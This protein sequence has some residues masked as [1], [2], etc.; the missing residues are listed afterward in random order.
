MDDVQI[1][2][3][4][5]I[6]AEVVGGALLVLVTVGALLLAYLLLR[7]TRIAANAPAVSCGLRE[8]GRQRWRTSFVLLGTYELEA[9]S[10]LGLRMRPTRTWPR[11]LLEVSTPVDPV[12]PVPALSDAVIVTLTVLDSPAV[13]E[14]AVERTAYPA[15]RSW[16]ESAPPR[17][18]S[19]V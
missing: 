1:E 18:N 8:R 2:D 9:F 5:L 7:R 4:P 13:H 3:V 11:G 6:A 15:L 19:V 17:P 10:V 12:G 14:L 16:A